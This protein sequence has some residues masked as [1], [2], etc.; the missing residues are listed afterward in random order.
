MSEHA[1]TIKSAMKTSLKNGAKMYNHDVEALEQQQARVRASAIVDASDFVLPPATIAPPSSPKADDDDLKKEK[2]RKKERQRN[3]RLAKFASAQSMNGLVRYTKNSMKKQDP[4]VGSDTLKM[5][6]LEEQWQL[7]SFVSL[8]MT[9][10]FF[11]IF[12]VFFQRHYGVIDIFFA[13]SKIRSE[14]ATTSEDVQTVDGLFKWAEDVYFPFVWDMKANTSNKQLVGGVL[15]RTARSQVTPCEDSVLDGLDCF[16]DNRLVVPGDSNWFEGVRWA[17]P[18]PEEQ[19]YLGGGNFTLPGVGRRL[20][21]MFLGQEA[22]STPDPAA[23]AGR[24]LGRAP[25]HL[26]TY[27]PSSY[28]GDEYEQTLFIP[29]SLSLEQVREVLSDLMEL[30]VVQRST[31]M[32]GLQMLVHNSEFEH[33]LLTQSWNTFVFGRGGT[34]WS[35]ASIETLVLEFSFG[36]S[37]VGGVWCLFVIT[38]TILVGFYAWQALK[39]DSLFVYLTRLWNALEVILS[40]YGIVLV[41]MLAIEMVGALDFVDIYDKYL[42][43]TQNN[44][45]Y[46][47]TDYTTLLGIDDARGI[48]TRWFLRIEENVSNTFI[49][50]SILQ[51]LIADYHIV[52]LIRFVL[53]SRGQPRLAIIVNTMRK[54]MVD[55]A[56]LLCVMCIIYAAYVSSGHILFGSRLEAYSTLQGALADCFSIVLTREYSWEDLTEWDFWT[57]TIWVW[58]FMLLVVLVLVNIVLAMI[59][60]T[61]AEVREGIS[62]DSTVWKS[63]YHLTTMFKYFSSW[64]PTTKLMAGLNQMEG[65]KRRPKMVGPNDLREAF[66]EMLDVQV[67]FLFEQART[68]IDTAMKTSINAFPEAASCLLVSIDGLRNSVHDIRQQCEKED[69]E[70]FPKNAELDLLSGAPPSREPEWVKSTLRPRLQQQLTLLDKAQMRMQHCRKQAGTL[71]LA[72]KSPAYPVATPERPPRA[73]S[74]SSRGDDQLAKPMPRAKAV[75]KVTGLSA[76]LNNTWA[77]G[78]DPQAPQAIRPHPPTPLDGGSPRS[79]ASSTS[80]RAG[81]PG[82]VTLLPTSFRSSPV[83]GLPQLRPPPPS[84]FSILNDVEHMTQV[85]PQSEARKER[86]KEDE[87]FL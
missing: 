60:E 15:I 24:R 19:S 84:H 17:I 57:V 73:T 35:E 83:A 29:K 79:Q 21:S 46:T 64:V 33:A 12:M 85:L 38:L 9:T 87:E 28:P 50:S 10:L 53:A 41:V 82:S 31:T 40:M 47:I 68:H 78:T 56:H 26:R 67:E 65:D 51:V 13:E 86:L 77:A 39:R 22:G 20:Q 76:Y 48:D 75:G 18:N 16:P 71:G 59:F 44:A 14:L 52:L 32:F 8:P 3:D 34:L 55:F 81:S 37:M 69:A 30:Q 27:L 66:P 23:G 5:A 63:A 4:M 11:V 70:K 80:F 7:T 2:K 58:S 25:A 74:P 54:A 43:D 49:A 61:Y 62:G 72:A 36:T 45:A 42:D 1:D 6:V